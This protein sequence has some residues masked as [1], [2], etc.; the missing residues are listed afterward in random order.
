MPIYDLDT[1]QRFAAT[2][3]GGE[4][5]I[6]AG[7]GSGKTRLLVSRYLHYIKTENLPLSAIAAI[8]F[9]N[10]A[11]N[12]MKVR[13][14]EKAHELAEKNPHD[15][16]MWLHVAEN[17]HHAPISTI[18][19]FCSSI[20]RSH[21]VEAG[22]DPFYT[23]I[24]EI[25]NSELKNNVIKSFIDSRLTEEPDE[26]AFLT[27]T[28]GMSGLKNMLRMFLNK[29]IHVVK[30][31]DNNENTGIID[32]A[33]LQKS[34][35]RSLLEQVKTYLYVLEE[36]HALRPGSD[37]LTSIYDMLVENLTKIRDM[38]ENEN[39]DTNYIKYC[40]DSIVLKGG[41]SKNRG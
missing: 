16:D 6:S 18:H 2:A 3:T 14:S 8:T 41:S 25:T 26:M 1:D 28:F 5:A 38:I 33:T 9:T 15:R 30:Y 21:P 31:L 20:L 37:R 19:S 22:I 27:D 40:I 10:R 35:I 34:Y 29:R 12:Q 32:I 11:A 24:D 4:V 17:A 36:F 23:V 39:V 13:I 7:A